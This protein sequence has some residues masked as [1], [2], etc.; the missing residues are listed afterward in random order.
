M[1]VILGYARVSTQTQDITRQ[2]RNIKAV[3]P[4][5]IM[6]LE[7]FTGTKMERPEWTKLYKTIM[8]HLDL[9]H[10]VILVFD[11]VSR[12]SRNAEEGFK[13]YQELY[14]KGVTLIFLNEPHINTDTFKKATEKKIELQGTKEDIILNAINLYLM[15]LAKEQ[16]KIAFD[17]AEKEVDDLRKRTKQGIE[18]ARLRGKQIGQ[19]K[20]ARLKVKNEEPIKA[21]IKEFSFEKGLKDA[22]VMVIINNRIYKNRFNKKNEPLKISTTTYYKY[23]KELKNTL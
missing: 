2:V 12:M 10:K 4:D 14:D 13:L 21:I 11:S 3:Y 6:V 1:E 18:T 23:K 15:E 7:A 8:K 22:D 5:A 17:Q 16:I 19:V 20:G 9:C